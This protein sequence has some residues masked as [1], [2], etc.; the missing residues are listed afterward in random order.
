MTKLKHGRHTAER[1]ALR[2]S[3]KQEIKNAGMKDKIHFLSRKIKEAVADKKKDDAAKFLNEFIACCDK[4]AK[5]NVYHLNKAGHL[6]S[7]YMGMVRKV[8]AQ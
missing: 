8:T 2:K 5:N 1:K 3:R 7:R 4:A 6:K